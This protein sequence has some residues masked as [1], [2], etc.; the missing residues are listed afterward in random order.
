MGH[1]GCHKMAAIWGWDI[2][3]IRDFWTMIKPRRGRGFAI[4]FTVIHI[5][6]LVTAWGTIQKLGAWA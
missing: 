1:M 5:W 6:V 2:T 3:L 4:T